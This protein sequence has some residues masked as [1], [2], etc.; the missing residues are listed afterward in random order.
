MCACA[1][2]VCFL[3]ESSSNVSRYAVLDPKVVKLSVVQ[4][5]VI[6]YEFLSVIIGKLWPDFEISRN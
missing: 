6:S 1:L 4:H 2:F 5:Q 3:E